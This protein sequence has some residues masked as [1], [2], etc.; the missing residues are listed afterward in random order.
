MPSYAA[1]AF[2]HG[3][4][5]GDGGGSL[6]QI[7]NAAEAFSRED[8]L[9]A[10]ASGAPRTSSKVAEAYAHLAAITGLPLGEVERHM[11]RVSAE[12]FAKRLELEQSV[13]PNLELRVYAGGH[14]FYTHAR[15]NKCSATSRQCIGLR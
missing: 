14:M 3:K 12:L 15:G 8:L 2:H 11:G 7:T 6:E 5:R 10:L 4:Y 1:T 13:F 9:V